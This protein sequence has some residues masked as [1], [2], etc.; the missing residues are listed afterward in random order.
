MGRIKLRRIIKEDFPKEYDALLDKLLFP[1]NEA[2]DQVSNVLNNGLSVNDNMAG[3]DMVLDVTAPVNSDNPIYFKK[4]T[5]KSPCKGIVCVS[6]SL[7]NNT[8]SAPTGTPF[9]TF[10]DAGSNVKVTNITNLVSGSR[11]FLRIYAF[12]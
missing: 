2:I 6:A 12:A 3:Q 1:L 5:L 8:S 11:Y 10:E 9:F 4:T 7:A